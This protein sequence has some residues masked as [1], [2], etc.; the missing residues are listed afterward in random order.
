MRLAILT[1][2]YPPEIG[3]PQ[4]RLSAIARGAV[5]RGHSVT[6][7]AAKP[8][9]PTGRISPGYPGFV[10]RG[11]Q[12]GATVLRTV[13]YPTKR[14]EL[15]P[16]LACYLSFVA[17]SSLAGTALLAA[18]DYLMVESPP[19]F[20]GLAGLW[21]GWIKSCR[22]IFNVS[23]LW[24]ESAVRLGFV[25]PGSA[26][27]RW[28]SAL[29]SLCYRRAWLVTGQTAAI[30]ADIRRRF[31]GVPTHHLPNGVDT[32][33][34][35]PGSAPPA[36]SSQEGACTILY[37]GLL[38]LA[39]G[40]EQ[41]LDAAADMA[42]AGGVRFEFVGDGPFRPTLAER[43]ADPR[44]R[45]VRLLDPRP[46]SEMP[47]LLA[48]ADILVVP[49]HRAFTDAVPSKLFE[50]LASGRPVVVIATGEAAR[51][52]EEADAGIVV[53]HDDRAALAGALR[54]LAADPALRA[55]LGANG[56]AAAVAR[57]DRGRIIDEFTV[58]LEQ[59]LMERRA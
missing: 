2:Y 41:L 58:R 52:V 59:G 50:A 20:L 13:V 47:A 29:E 53:G 54:R 6:V 55:R 8:N 9:Y 5:R 43:A 10:A 22:V 7:I 17:S 39:Q 34:F 4:A 14:A 46:H 21:L 42:E 57:Y 12:D 15:V 44:M 36:G 37:A 27:H 26:G 24:P 48:A 3:A 32:D 38:G 40:L 25:R 30:V 18:P 16:R 28:S 11:E 31:P 49:L 19:L 1:Q 51:I 33:L 56:R 23:D 45:H 35:L